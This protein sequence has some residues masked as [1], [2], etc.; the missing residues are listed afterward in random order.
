MN[1]ASYLAEGLGDVGA[2]QHGT[3][4]FTDGGDDEAGAERER[5]GAP[6]G[7]EVVGAVVGT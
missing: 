1:G 6:G 7:G 2:E 3:T 4:K 5:A